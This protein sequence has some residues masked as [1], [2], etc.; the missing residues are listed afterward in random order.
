MKLLG[1]SKK[2]LNKNEKNC[3]EVQSKYLLSFSY[4]YFF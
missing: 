4:Q 3:L 1:L 2:K